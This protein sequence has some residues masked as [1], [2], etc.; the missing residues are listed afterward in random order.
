MPM[1]NSTSA[2][3]LSGSCSA[4]SGRVL[5]ERVLSG[6]ATSESGNSATYATKRLRV[7]SRSSSPSSSSNTSSAR[8]TGRYTALSR[9]AKR[10][11]MSQDM[12]WRKRG[13]WSVISISVSKV[14]MVLPCFCW[15]TGAIQRTRPRYVVSGYASTTMFTSWP[16]STRPMSISAMSPRTIIWL[17][18]PISKSTV[19]PEYDESPEATTSP[20]STLRRMTMPSIGARTRISSSATWS[21]EIW[22][23]CR[24]ALASSMSSSSWAKRR[25]VRARVRRTSASSN[26]LAGIIL[27]SKRA[28]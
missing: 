21:S 20:I 12:P 5:S 28:F 3:A 6:T 2:K 15:P 14:T 26:C 17:G 19:P 7:T 25:L 1:A 9:R 10:M 22:V 27:L 11:S 18:S 8:S 13:A 16:T 23:R 4:L 24:L